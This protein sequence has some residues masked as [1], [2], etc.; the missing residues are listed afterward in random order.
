VLP[1]LGPTPIPDID[2][3]V[4]PELAMAC[5]VPVA[6]LA[7]LTGV[8][9]A[10]TAGAGAGEVK[11]IVLEDSDGEPGPEIEGAE[12]APITLP[13]GGAAVSAPWTTF[14]LAAPLDLSQTPSPWIAILVSRGKL[15]W[16][17][18]QY[19][20]AAQAVPVRRGPPEGPW[21]NLPSMFQRS[22]GFRDAAGQLLD[23]SRLGAR[24][25]AIGL[26]P[27]D[28]PIA[29][30]RVAIT[31]SESPA[32]DA[33]T[34]VPVTPTAKGAAIEW[35]PSSPLPLAAS[36]TVQVVSFVAGSLTLRDLDVTLAK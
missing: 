4:T 29:P 3:V 11:V 30:Y 22:T 28:A 5:R 13:T 35:T 23:L 32:I 2:L 6:G 15:A 27:A 16:S 9:L 31:A 12:S 20:D 7:S 24:I 26:P 18:G 10:L 19:S 36:L 21:V 33:T 25:R 17:M 34:G 14:Q 1:P 8:R